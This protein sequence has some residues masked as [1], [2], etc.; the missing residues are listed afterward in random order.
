V[1]HRKTT[2]NN[3]INNTV[4]VDTLQQFSLQYVFSKRTQA[5]CLA[6]DLAEIFIAD[7]TTCTVV[8][9]IVE[10]VIFGEI[11]SFFLCSER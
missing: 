5:A 10:T 6:D 9:E 2:T 1:W 8:S 7:F 3:S 11:C 4:V